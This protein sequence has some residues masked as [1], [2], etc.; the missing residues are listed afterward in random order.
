MKFSMVERNHKSIQEDVIIETF[1]KKTFILSFPEDHNKHNQVFFLLNQKIKDIGDD[2]KYSPRFP[3]LLLK[4]NGKSLLK[5][6][7]VE[8]Q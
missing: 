1:S 8:V 6:N 4:K 5:D 3:D 7:E 2:E